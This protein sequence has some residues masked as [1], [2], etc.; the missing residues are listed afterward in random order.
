M[1]DNC[2][3][4]LKLLKGNEIEIISK[5]R[6]EH[7]SLRGYCKHILNHTS[8]ECLECLVT[9]TVKHYICE[10]MVFDKQRSEMRKELAKLDLQFNEEEFFNIQNIL[11]PHLWVMLPDPEDEDYKELWKEATRKR[12]AA[13]RIVSKFVIS[14]QRFYNQEII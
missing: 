3:H 2:K 8:G 13:L 4:E 7:I 14:S 5:L 6:S 9:E 1:R 12:A 11:F 10:C